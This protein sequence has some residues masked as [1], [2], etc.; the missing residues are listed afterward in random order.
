VIA[1]GL[2]LGRG[3]DTRKVPEDAALVGNEEL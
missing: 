2:L 3:K 1:A